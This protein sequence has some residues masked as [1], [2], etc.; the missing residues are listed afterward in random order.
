[1]WVSFFFAFFMNIDVIFVKNIFD[2]TTAWAYISIAVLW[3]FLI[4]LLL[5]VETVYYW[6]IMEHKKNALPKHIVINPLIMMT[7]IV[8]W[9]IIF[10]FFFW[11]WILNFLKPELV[12]YYNIYM[13]SLIY[14]GFLAYISFFSK[15]LVWWGNTYVNKVLSVL[16]IILVILIYTFSSTLSHF[17]YVFISLWGISVLILW[18]LFMKELRKL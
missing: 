15:I 11:K 7:L 18:Y 13:L 17:I 8:I 5:S 4:F 16:S 9:A 1:M 12:N 2:S 6:Q 3:K 10:N 14:Y